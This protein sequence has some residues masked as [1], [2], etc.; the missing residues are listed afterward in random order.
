MGID[1]G[2]AN[3]GW[4]IISSDLPGKYKHVASGHVKTYESHPLG[5]R[6]NKIVEEVKKHIYGL[7]AIGIENVYF[8]R[9]VSSAMTTANVIGALSMIAYQEGGIEVLHI[10]PNEVKSAVVGQSKGITKV[11]VKHYTKIILGDAIKDDMTDHEIDAMA[12]A[13]CTFQKI[14]SRP[15]AWDQIMKRQMSKAQKTDNIYT[16]K[17]G[18]KYGKNN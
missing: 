3:T 6:I 2:I 11:Q 10:R 7:K 18:G 13:I 4:A 16:G 17:K 8:G 5:C 15:S 14:R 9:N 12:A 1:P